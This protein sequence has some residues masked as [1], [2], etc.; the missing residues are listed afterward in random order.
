[1]PQR[2]HEILQEEWR[3][4]HEHEQRHVPVIEAE[5]APEQLKEQA[6]RDQP[7]RA[8]EREHQPDRD[9][10]GEQRND[11]ADQRAFGEAE[12]IIGQQMDVGDVRRQ[13][14]LVEE[15]PDYYGDIDDQ[16]QAPGVLP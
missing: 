1:M 13:R 15:N 16:H 11:R 4:R 10:C 9:L 7:G 3:A 5:G 8:A 6:E 14:D 12:M 2:M